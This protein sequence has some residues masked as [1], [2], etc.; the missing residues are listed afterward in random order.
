[1]VFPLSCPRRTPTTLL[2]EVRDTNLAWWSV[3]DRRTRGWTTDPQDSPP[4]WQESAGNERWNN[5][6][7]K[8]SLTQKGRTNGSTRECCQLGN[9]IR[10]GVHRNK[11]SKNGFTCSVVVA[12][13]L[14]KEWNWSTN[15]SRFSWTRVVSVP[16]VFR[17][18][19]LDMF[20]WSS[21]L[22]S[23]LLFAVLVFDYRLESHDSLW[24]KNLFGGPR[25]R[26]AVSTAWVSATGQKMYNLD[27]RLSRCCHKLPSSWI[28]FQHLDCKQRISCKMT[29][30]K[31]HAVPPPNHGSESAKRL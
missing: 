13:I 4:K 23:L 31:V 8:T 21:L 26:D 15:E 17:D 9:W 16:V 29:K 14:E 22:T 1:M 25:D 5:W 11:G 18:L 7:Y 2:C 12:T 30:N 6:A 28:I 20:F 10:F 19:I 27:R 24:E 3:T